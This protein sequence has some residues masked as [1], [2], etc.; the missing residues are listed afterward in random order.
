MTETAATFADPEM[1]TITDLGTERPKTYGE[2][3]YL[4][5]NNIDEGIRKNMRKKSV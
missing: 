4:E 1:P 3:T 5:K 2:L